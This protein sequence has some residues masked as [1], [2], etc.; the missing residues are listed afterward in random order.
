MGY[1]KKSSL[2]VS[3]AK[4]LPPVFYLEYLLQGLHG[5]DAPG[6]EL[7]I[8][9]VMHFL[10]TDSVEEGEK[11]VKTALDNFGRIGKRISRTD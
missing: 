3:C 11:L 10:F 8:K 5:V 6:Y 1:I 7:W 4:L 2:N 9:R